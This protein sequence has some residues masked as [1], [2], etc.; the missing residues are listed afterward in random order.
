MP[1]T[2]RLRSLANWQPS[3]HL[4]G[5]RRRGR[6]DAMPR[7]AIAICRDDTVVS[8]GETALR[9]AGYEVVRAAEPRDVLDR[10]PSLQPELIILDL[11]LPSNGV[12]DIL[13]WIGNQRPRPALVLVSS[14]EN[15][16]VLR[17]GFVVP[18]FQ[19]LIKPLGQ[20]EMSQAVSRVFRQ[21]RQVSSDG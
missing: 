13:H 19:L 3:C 11:D 4:L 10:L 20:D 2:G 21:V 1:N 7:T 5:S 8:S 9:K 6:G 15:L 17:E 14:G 18:D 16:R 12:A